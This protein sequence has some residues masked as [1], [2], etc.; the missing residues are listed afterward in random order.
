MASE[1]PPELP[2]EVISNLQVAFAQVQATQN[3]FTF[4]IEVAPLEHKINISVLDLEE[5][6]IA[7]F[8]QCKPNYDVKNFRTDLLCENYLKDVADQIGKKKIILKN[9]CCN[10]PHCPQ[11]VFIKCIHEF[12][13]SKQVE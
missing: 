3:K 11:T 7:L 8:K 6:A 12:A 4:P 2:P 10:L 5:G 1:L 13:S 9:R